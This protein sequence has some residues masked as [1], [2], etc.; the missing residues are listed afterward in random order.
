MSTVDVKNGDVV[1]ERFRIDAEIGKGGFGTVFKACDMRTNQFV[2]LK[3]MHVR[4]TGNSSQVK[5]FQRESAMVAKLQHPNIVTTIDYG[6]TTSGIPFIVFE[7]LEGESL[8]QK[9]RRDG[10][11]SVWRVGQII[12]QVLQALEHAHGHDLVHRD[13][14]PANIF[15]C[16]GR[17]ADFARVVDFGIAKGL[18]P[19]GAD[20]TK[21]TATGQ[22]IGTPHYMAPEQ[23]KG[24]NIGHNADL[25]SLGL[26][27][28]EAITG[29]RV[30]EGDSSISIL[31]K[32]LSKE[33]V[34]LGE[35]VL[36]SPFGEVTRRAVEKDASKRYPTA[37]AMLAD[38]KAVLERHHSAM[39]AASSQALS[40][41]PS[42]A[43]PVPSTELAPAL[44]NSQP[45]P[46][47]PSAAPAP[48]AYSSQAAPVVPSSPQA[49]A[50]LQPSSAPAPAAGVA[51]GD[52][53]TM[54]LPHEMNLSVTYPSAGAMPSSAAG[55]PSGP[56]H[57]PVMQAASSH[58]APGANYGQASQ[59]Y[60]SSSA[61]Y[62]AAS[63]ANYG[64]GPGGG[65]GP[66]TPSHMSGYGA[67]P[68]SN[69][70]GL[71]VALPIIGLLLVGIFGALAYRTGSEGARAQKDDD[72]SSRSERRDQKSD[73]DSS[74]RDD[75]DES[76]SKSRSGGTDF[77]SYSGSSL[78]RKLEKAG[79]TM[80]ATSSI[81]RD[82]PG[83]KHSLLHMTKAKK[84]ATVQLFAYESE[85]MAKRYVKASSVYSQPGIYWGNA[86]KNVIQVSMGT[87]HSDARALLN[88]LKE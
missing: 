55:S 14:K 30:V 16:A 59:P 70:T 61:G 53:V 43:A 6:H 24:L 57:I 34:P 41:T 84:E 81:D 44:V 3:A 32:Q 29:K 36:D 13:I 80:L 46:V 85:A 72:D 83:C 66:G 50:S 38:V 11:L 19:E 9:V 37:S 60:P 58:A 20:V 8:K 67:P 22:A 26:V 68:R 63:G 33:A 12:L 86:G 25:Y 87:H 17:N 48:A 56:A 27:M 74:N 54:P 79:W 28:A 64:S 4:H 62:G 21:L 7:L 49:A 45:S 5:R 42:V 39:Q 2:A 1:A 75:S 31:M 88:W 73:D 71:F 35:T 10:A 78:K 23:I 76:G 47:V 18:T 15:L 77:A 65:Y 52:S 69:K 51:I 82:V 40:G